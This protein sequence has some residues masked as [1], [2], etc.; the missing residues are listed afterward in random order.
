M[1]QMNRLWEVEDIGNRPHVAT[2]VAHFDL[3]NL[4]LRSSSR[5]N[6]IWASAAG[7]HQG[8]QNLFAVGTSNGVMLVHLWDRAMAEDPW[9]GGEYV[10]DT[11]AVDFWGHW[12]VLSGMRNGKVRLWDLRSHGSNVRFQHAS[13]VVNIKSLDRN[14]ILVAGHKDK[15]CRVLFRRC[16]RVIPLPIT[17]PSTKTEPALHIRRP[18]PQSVS[19]VR[20]N[21][22]SSP[23]ATRP[24]LSDLS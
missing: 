10:A 4:M 17:V 22:R 24:H 14:Q 2:T 15:V 19:P 12:N 13:C 1:I 23:I 20:T 3:S 8:N 21:R 6:T 7:P 9:A 11:L 5:F 18:L 16:P